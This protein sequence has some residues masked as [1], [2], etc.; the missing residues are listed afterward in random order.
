M[1]IQNSTPVI[2]LAQREPYISSIDIG[3]DDNRLVPFTPTTGRIVSPPMDEVA[4]GL[5]HH[6]NLKVARIVGTTVISLNQRAWTL[7]VVVN[8]RPPNPLSR[9]CSIIAIIM[10]EIFAFE[11]NE[12]EV[13]LRSRYAREVGR[14]NETRGSRDVTRDDDRAIPGKS[15]RGIV[16]PIMNEVIAFRNDDLE[17]AVCTA[18]ALVGALNNAPRSRRFVGDNGG[19]PPRKT[20]RRIISIV[21]NEIIPLQNDGLEISGLS[22]SADKV[23]LDEGGCAG[24]FVADYRSTGPVAVAIISKVVDD[25]V[26]LENENF[27]VAWVRDNAESTLD[28]CAGRTGAITDGGSACPRLLAAAVIAI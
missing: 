4:V 21:V 7:G 24:G 13:G 11:S 3:S 16:A 10:D 9:T 12:F 5:I 28:N 8:N 14:L 1:V 20:G 25:I 2:S 17:I 26:A 19:G 6:D 23:A 22:R 15:G 18:T 27:K